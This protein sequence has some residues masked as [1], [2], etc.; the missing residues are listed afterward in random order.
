MSPALALLVLVPLGAAQ[1]ACGKRAG[2]VAHR[3]VRIGGLGAAVDAPPHWEAEAVSK[4]VYRVG[5][6]PG[7][8]VFVREVAF[9][10]ATIDELYAT[11]CARAIE[12]GTK[13]MTPAGAMLVE[14]RLASATPDGASVELVHVASLLRAGEHGIKCHFGIA[15]DAAAATATA[16]C[17]S[18]RR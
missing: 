7:E 15:D 1:L 4:A 13:A 14:C 5:A 9:A 10:P 17:R 18:L 12:P 11:E 3:A 6:G 2:P 8:Q 16:V